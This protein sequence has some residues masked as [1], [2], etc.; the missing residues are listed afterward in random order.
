MI[1]I[2]DQTFQKKKPDYKYVP[3]QEQYWTFYKI[4]R[5][6]DKK[7]PLPTRGDKTFLD[8]WRYRQLLQYKSQW[9]LENLEN[10]L[11]RQKK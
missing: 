3:V 7:I 6:R 9:Y 2:L 8:P 11:K 4:I 10:L 5:K 1:K